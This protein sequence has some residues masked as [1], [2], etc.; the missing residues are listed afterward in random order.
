VCR[1]RFSRNAREPPAENGYAG[2]EARGE[3]ERK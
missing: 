2:G 3:S 1:R